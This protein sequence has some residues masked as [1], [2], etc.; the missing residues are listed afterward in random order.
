MSGRID[1]NRKPFLID[2]GD[3]TYSPNPEWLID[4]H[5]ESDGSK[6]EATPHEGPDGNAQEES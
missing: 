5:S 6:G 3:G 4:E 2:N 1:R